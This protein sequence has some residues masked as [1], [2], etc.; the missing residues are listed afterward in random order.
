MRF[1]QDTNRQ[2]ISFFTLLY[3]LFV[4]HWTNFWFFSSLIVSLVLVVVDQDR[5][6][7]RSMNKI[8]NSPGV[9]WLWWPLHRPRRSIVVCLLLIFFLCVYVQS[10]FERKIYTKKANVTPILLIFTS[11]DCEPILCS[12]VHWTMCEC[13]NLHLH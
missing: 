10:K 13:L 6:V 11:F 5:R 9:L 12:I 3:F 7:E 1:K 4:C 2:K 8:L